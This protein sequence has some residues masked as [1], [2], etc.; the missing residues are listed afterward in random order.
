MKFVM[1]KLLADPTGSEE[2]GMECQR[3]QNENPQWQALTT[4]AR[5]QVKLG[6]GSDQARWSLKD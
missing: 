3:R 5:E 1:D 2:L 4:H 6:N